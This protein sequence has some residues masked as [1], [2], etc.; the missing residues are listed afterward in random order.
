[1]ARSKGRKNAQ[2]STHPSTDS[3][4]RSSPSQAT[5]HEGADRPASPTPSNATTADEDDMDD[6]E[7]AQGGEAA[8]RAGGSDDGDE[9]P[10]DG[11]VGNTRD[12]GAREGRQG[13][14]VAD[15]DVN[16]GS[17]AQGD[18]DVE[19]HRAVDGGRSGDGDGDDSGH[20]SPDRAPTPTLSSTNPSSATGTTAG[21]TSSPPSSRPTSVASSSG[22]E[23][24]RQGANRLSLA[25]SDDSTGERDDADDANSSS[26]RP[27][28]LSSAPETPTSPSASSSS[29][30]HPPPL[31]RH[32]SSLLASSLSGPA[33]DPTNVGREAS[34]SLTQAVWRQSLG[35]NAS[36]GAKGLV[37]VVLSDNEEEGEEGE[38]GPSTPRR[39][40]AN[41]SPAKRRSVLSSSAGDDDSHYGDEDLDLDAEADESRDSFPS[42]SSSHSP[43]KF[44]STANPRFP[45]T[46]AHLMP[47]SPSRDR[48][49]SIATPHAA[50]GFISHRASTNLSSTTTTSSPDLAPKASNGI[51]KLQNEFLKVKEQEGGAER[52]GIDWDFWGRVM[53]DYEEVARTQP[54]ELSRAIQRG[55]PPAL[56]GMVWQLMAAAKDENLEFVYSELLKQSSPHEKSIA[57]DLSRTFPKH[58]YFSDAQ[59]VG[60]ENLFNVVKAY[61]LYDDEVGYTQGLQF[62]VGPLLLNMPDEEAFCVLVRLMKAYDL[63]SHYTP[64]MPGLQLRL[65]QFDR[66]VEELLP[67]VFLHLLRQGVKSSMYASQWFLTLFGYRFPLELVSSVFDLVFAE[68]VEAVFRFAIALLKRSEPYLLTLEFEE[69][70]DFLKNGLFEVYAPDEEELERDPQAQYKVHE[71]VREA[72]Q[73]RITPMMLDQF[74]E[75]WANLCAAQTAHAAELDSLRKANLQLSLQVRQLETSL[76]QINQEHCELVKQVVASRLEREELEDEL[77]KYKLAYADLSHLAAASQASTSPLQMRRQSEMSISSSLSL[78]PRETDEDTSSRGGGSGRGSIG[79]GFGLGGGR[80]FSGSSSAMSQ[81]GSTQGY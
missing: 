45:R 38:E 55:I 73:V 33:Q 46:S 8:S 57:R 63:R 44:T 22:I 13:A 41:G 69:L 58:E 30:P 65:F 6:F 62:I 48:Q 23:G 34:A 49:G 7:D 54:R 36:P 15:D 37:D 72:L 12:D 42:P 39:R 51:Q 26:K 67:S 81:N 17:T 61:S 80:W 79:G 18:A 19:A 71:F 2:Q 1:M 31:P 66:L 28:S 64:N 53:N 56:R 70:I 78:E 40:G 35:L 60:Q 59:G 9:E 29:A 77:V 43:S 11:Q 75:E 52:E 5:P 4:D 10:A 68:G 74:G 20:S 14:E 50:D 16:G 76:A 32:R 21:R 25:L 3:S 47:S 24:L 27:F